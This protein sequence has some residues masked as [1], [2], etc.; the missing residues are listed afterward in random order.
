VFD[1]DFE[2]A[3]LIFSNKHKTWTS[4]WNFCKQ[5]R[6][7]ERAAPLWSAPGGT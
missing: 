7:V 1:C 2:D 4:I 3:L 6:G 5:I